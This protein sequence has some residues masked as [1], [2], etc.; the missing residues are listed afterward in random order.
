MKNTDEDLKKQKSFESKIAFREKKYLGYFESVKSVGR[1]S[2]NIYK[3][4]GSERNI[5]SAKLASPFQTVMMKN[6]SSR[7]STR[8]WCQTTSINNK[9]WERVRRA[10]YKIALL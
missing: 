4:E 5:S 8:A 9:C 6:S 1:R 3:A 10:I 2:V 7:A